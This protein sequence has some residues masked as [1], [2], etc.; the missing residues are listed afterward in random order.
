MTLTGGE[1]VLKI[2]DIKTGK[3]L[4]T[5]AGHTGAVAAVAFSPD[6]KRIATGSYDRTAKVWD[7]ETGKELLALGGS[8]EYC[9]RCG[10]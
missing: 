5:L 1:G 10:F 3:E 9:I 2:W 4:L 8:H 6:G 7:A